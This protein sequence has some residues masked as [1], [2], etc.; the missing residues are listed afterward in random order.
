MDS[1][2]EEEQQELD[3]RSE[4]VAEKYQ[5]AADIVNAAMSAVI[6]AVKPGA[7]IVDVC[8]VGDKYIKEK[9]AEAYSDTKL[10]RG[11]AFPTCVSVNNIVGHFSPLSTETVALKEGDVVK[12]DLGA[13]IDGY[14]VQSA[15]TVIATNNAEECVTGKK[16]DVICAAHFAAE[17]ALRL[18]RAGRTNNEITQIWSEIA[19]TFNCRV[20]EGVLSHQLKRFIIDG[21]NCVLSK[22]NL[23]HKVSEVTFQEYDVFCFDIIMSTGEGKIKEGATKPTVFKRN[24][25]KTYSLKIQAARAALSEISKKFTIFPFSLR[26]LSDERK[27]KLG[28][29][30]ILKHELV[31]PFPVLEEKKGEFVAQFKFT[32]VITPEETRKYTQQDLPYV[33]SS[34]EITDPKIQEVL[35]MS[36][37]NDGSASQAAATEQTEQEEPK[38]N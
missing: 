18:F 1:S 37:S 22:E 6:E 31:E 34:L 25:D 2:S 11:I 24:V 17:A 13:H 10:E 36:T 35:N 8:T 16:A 27:A 29:T 9:T 5:A 14:I 21:N 19:N 12:I 7:K 20:V 4:E 23:D 26:N 33:Q 28:M 15:H 3:H 38:A 30:E 32:A